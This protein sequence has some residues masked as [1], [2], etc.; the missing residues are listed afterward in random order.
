MARYRHRVVALCATIVMLTTAVS[1]PAT[2]SGDID[3]DAA[4]RD[5]LTRRSDAEPAYRFPH[6][7]CFG[8]AALEHGLPETLLLAVA[9]GD[10]E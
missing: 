3:L 1:S 9:R 8:D 6:A 5:Y 7:S 10:G 4:W 2:V